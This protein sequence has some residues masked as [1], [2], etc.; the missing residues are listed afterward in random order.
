[1]ADVKPYTVER[2]IAGVQYVAQFCGLREAIRCMD[3]CAAGDGVNMEKFMAYILQH[4]IVQPSDLSMDDFDDMD[5]L[6]EVVRF[7]REVMQ[8][9]FRKERFF[10]CNKTK[11]G[12]S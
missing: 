8:G 6:S 5:T 1:M 4:I 7:G 3:D 2:E 12:A 10:E 9:R 11:N